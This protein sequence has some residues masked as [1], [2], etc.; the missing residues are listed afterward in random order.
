M[1]LPRLLVLTSTLPRWE[2]DT[3]PAFVEA[4]SLELARSFDV[5]VLAPHARGAAR[6]EK[7]QHQGR[8][9]RIHRFRYFIPGLESLAYEGGIMAKLRSNPLRIVLVPFFLVAQLF[10]IARLHRRQPFAVVHAHW[11]IPQGLVASCLKWVAKPVPYVVTAHGSDLYMLGSGFMQRLK[12]RAAQRA[13]TVTV[14]SEAMRDKVAALDVAADAVAVRSM[15]VDLETRFTPGE[16]VDREGLLFVGRLVDVKGVPVLVDAMAKLAVERPDVTLT[17]IGDGPERG[18]IEERISALGLQERVRMQGSLTQDEIVTA[19]R[20]AQVLVMPSVVTVDGAEE[21][22]GLVAVE[23]MGCGCAVVASDLAGIR[24]AVRDGETGLLASPGDAH[25]LA[26][27]IS[28]LLS[29][30]ALRDT[31]TRNARAHAVENYDWRV[32]GKEYA[33]LLLA[34]ITRD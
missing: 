29:D 25:D 34:T 21:G 15:G 11:L 8:T 6:D 28:T 3:E 23:A 33:R 17:V 9:I 26:E 32:V 1:S 27:K 24:D 13:T 12:R 10:A 20:A 14:V 31:L 7:R 18:A 2:G 4:L 22:F 16:N 30:D 19:L 5:T